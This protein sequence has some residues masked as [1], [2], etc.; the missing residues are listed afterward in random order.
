MDKESP[1]VSEIIDKTLDPLN[2]ILNS[3]LIRFSN[4][5][6]DDLNYF[7]KCWRNAEAE[8]RIQVITGL[9]SLGEED[10]TLDFTG[11]FKHGLED[12]EEQV[13]IK[14][15]EG[16]ELEDKYIYIAP[17]IKTLKTDESEKVRSAAAQTLGKF[18][19]LAEQGDF[20]EIIARD[21]FTALLG[22]LEN[23]R[24]SMTLRR[25]A[26]ESIAPFHDELVA[27]YI[28][29]FYYSEDPEVKA[30]ALFSMGRNCDGRWL[31]FLINGMQSEVV[32]FRFESARASGELD[33]EDLV[34]YLIDLLHDRESQVQEAAIRSLGKIGGSKVKMTL[35]DLIKDPDSLIKEEAQFALKEL[36]AC[37]DPL[38]LNP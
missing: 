23:T 21:I 14:S 17:I 9:G 38:S 16:L 37:E 5:S 35:Q 12:P 15:I 13:R 8:R 33:D 31:D 24:E 19:L 36:L 27:N 2:K 6:A 34:P 25:R 11:I 20:S 1:A 28:E 7:K 22:I 32:E 3:D 18:A 29:D 26:L 4:L 30:S 10:F